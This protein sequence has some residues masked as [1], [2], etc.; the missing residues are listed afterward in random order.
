M[1]KGILLPTKPSKFSNAPLMDIQIFID[2]E[3]IPVWDGER[4]INLLN[5]LNHAP[6]DKDIINSF[7]DKTWV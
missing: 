4:Y 5:G 3:Y 7:A 6:N 2:E 1:I